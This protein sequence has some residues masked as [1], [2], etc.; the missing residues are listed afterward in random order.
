M[1]FVVPSTNIT[2]PQWL[3]KISNSSSITRH[4][5]E[6]VQR[7]ERAS[8][9]FQAVWDAP[10]CQSIQLPFVHPWVLPPPTRNCIILHTDAAF[11]AEMHQ[12]GMGFLARNSHG[13]VQ[14]A[15]SQPAIFLSAAIGEALTIKTAPLEVLQLGHKEIQVES[16][17]LVTNDY[18]VCSL[19]LPD[20]ISSA[21]CKSVLQKKK[22]L[23][24]SACSET[25]FQKDTLDRDTNNSYPGLTYQIWDLTNGLKV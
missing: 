10:H 15:I 5:G 11:N 17:C 24:W 13:V 21:A 16:D 2:F 19:L 14:L 9:E 22:V 7:A 18:Q 6:V 1:S 3:L 25:N 20:Q 23:A 12:G 8:I 4:V